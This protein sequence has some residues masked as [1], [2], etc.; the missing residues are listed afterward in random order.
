MPTHRR[1]W[2]A[3][4]AG[5]VTGA[6]LLAAG[7]V[8]YLGY[9]GGPI[10]R[11]VPATARATM[12][13]T[14]VLFLS[15]DMGINA[16]MGPR[17]IAALNKDGLPVLAFNTLTAFGTR[18]TPD[19]AAAIV[20][21]AVARAERMPGTLRVVLVGQSFGADMLQFGGARLPRA[22]RPQVRQ[23]ILLVPGNTLL[24][25][26]SPG[27]VLDGRPDA[28]AAP[29][30]QR[31]NWTRVTCIQGAAEAAS[32]CPLLHNPNVRRVVLPGGHFL[33]YD[34]PLIV[35]TLRGVIA[36]GR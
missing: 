7:F 6:V 3:I 26:A 22:L 25:K 21:A 32:L 19:Q 24:F 35:R 18:R 36:S 30:A 27:G 13:G 20:A 23:V 12:P 28:P 33:N 29:S 15:G 10:L 34:V 14:R 2:L 5:T 4:V 16:G 11:D 1:N 8:G 31:L 9:F 17:L